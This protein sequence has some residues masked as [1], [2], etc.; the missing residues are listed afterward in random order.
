MSADLTNPI[1][2]DENEARKHLEILRWPNG[3]VC[4]HCG[5][6][7]KITKL[8]GESHRPGVYQCNSCR[9]QFTVTVGTLV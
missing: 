8:E 2:T 6:S 7:E 1:F 9:Q 5:E 3:P 4:P